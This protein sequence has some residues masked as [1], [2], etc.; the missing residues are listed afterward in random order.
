[1]LVVA[2]FFVVALLVGIPLAFVMGGTGIIHLL[3]LDNELFLQVIPQRL[4]MG[5]NNIT[6]T[7][8]PFFIIAGQI[9]NVG[10]ITRKLMDAARELV[11]HLKGG[12]AYTTVLVSVVLS[13]IIGA[14]QAVA[15]ILCTVMLPEMKKDGYEPEFSASLIAAASVLGP[16]IPPSVVFVT[17]SVRADVGVKALFMGGIVPGICLAV[18]YAVLIFIKSRK[19]DF[20]VPNRKFDLKSCVMC[21]IKAIPALLIPFIIVGGIMFGIFT[22]TESGAVAVVAAIVVGLLYGTLD[23]RKLPKILLD[24]GVTSAGILFIIAFGNVIGWTMAMGGIPEMIKE[25][26]FSVTTNP[27]II[28]FMMLVVLIIVGCLMDVTAASLLFIP[29]MAPLAISIGMDPIHWGVIFCIMLCIGFITPPVGQV[30]F[31]ISNV[32][33]ISFS[34]LCRTILPFCMVAFI[35]TFSLAYM[36]NVMMWLPKMFS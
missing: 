21:F 32:S 23:L 3:T 33:D 2:I 24:A 29:V 14:A 17:Y 6:L 16:I 19:K 8:L 30:L 11:G 25:A 34:K 7:C 27:N 36:P 5:V 28:L 20:P 35:V 1:M 4:F 18:G 9:M 26:I 13:A 15:S 10:G 22:P 31:V 12:L